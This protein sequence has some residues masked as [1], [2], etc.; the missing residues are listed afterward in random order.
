MRI[1]LCLKR[2]KTIGRLFIRQLYWVV[3]LFLHKKTWEGE[4]PRLGYV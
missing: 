2:R 1:R 3:H 4:L